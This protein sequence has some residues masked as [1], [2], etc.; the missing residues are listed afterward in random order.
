LGWVSNRHNLFVPIY[1][2]SKAIHFLDLQASL[3][4]IFNSHRE[5]DCIL[6]PYSEVVDG[7]LTLTGLQSVKRVDYD[8]AKSALH[9][10]LLPSYDRYAQEPESQFVF[11]HGHP[12]LCNLLT[13]IGSDVAKMSI[14]KTVIK[15]NDFFSEKLGKSLE[16]VGLMVL[17]NGIREGKVER[18]RNEVPFAS[19]GENLIINNVGSVIAIRDDSLKLQ[20]GNVMTVSRL[21]VTVAQKVDSSKLSG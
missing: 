11:L 9:K 2:I 13:Y 15:I 17:E 1:F 21:L 10:G 5:V 8:R 6:F 19:K 12:V 20:P 7:I 4:P 16:K 14:P 18:P 3:H